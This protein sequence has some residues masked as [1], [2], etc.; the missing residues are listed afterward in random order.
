VKRRDITIRSPQRNT[1]EDAHTAISVL[2]TRSEGPHAGRRVLVI[3]YG[4]TLRRD[5]GVGVRAA[6]LLRAE[7]RF[8]D[9]HVLAVHQLTPE[10][11]MDIGAASLVIFVDADTAAEPGTV[12]VRALSTAEPSA[13]GSGASSHHVGAAELVALARE[14]MGATPDAVAIGIGVADLEMGEG[15]SPAVEAA[16]PTVVETV[17]RAATVRHAGREA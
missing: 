1:A 8:A 9:V 11:A 4:N 10:L 14:L 2:P 6:E 12:H 13:G 7:P 15:L 16:L 3:G 17:A 5:D